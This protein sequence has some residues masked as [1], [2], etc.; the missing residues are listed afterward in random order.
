MPRHPDTTEYHTTGR[1]NPLRLARLHTAETPVEF[2]VFAT[3][4]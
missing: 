1:E 2:R 3:V 4:C